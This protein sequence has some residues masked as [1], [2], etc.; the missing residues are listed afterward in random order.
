MTSTMTFISRR[1]LAIPLLAVTAWLGACASDQASPLAHDLPASLLPDARVQF[2]PV[3]LQASDASVSDAFGSAVALSRDGNTLAVGADLKD[4]GAGAVYVYARMPQGW[5]QQA[6]LTAV[7]PTA[8]SG[9][10]F[11]LSLSDDGRRLAVGAPFE[12]LTGAE[13]GAAYLFEQ[14]DNTFVVR[15][16]LSASNARESDWFGASVALSGRGDALAVGARHEDGPTARPV[17]DSGA[18][19]VFGQGAGGWSE[20][21]YLKAS[22]AHAGDRF[23]ASVALSFDGATL[24]VGAQPRKR[25]AVRV[26]KR[27]PAGWR[28]QA[29]LQSR[30]AVAQ[31]RFGAQLAL[32]ANGDTLAVGAT[33]APGAAGAAHVYTQRGVLWLQQARLQA[34]QAQAGDA[35]GERLALSAD[36]SVL[37]VS[38]VH[39]GHAIEAGV[40]HLFA[41]GAASWSQ[42][43]RLTSANA[44]SGDLFGSALGLSGDG[45]L[46]A[47]GARLEDGPS[48]W[49]LG[50]MQ[51]G[52]RA[53]NIGAVHLLPAL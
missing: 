21:A 20:Q 5:V 33:G 7:V 22:S 25:G 38:A 43:R 47:V 24:A 9:F 53:Q 30:G 16:H 31:D 49:R 32:S 2:A 46:L 12:S 48:P 29:L 13:Q 37:A 51:L 18:V 17:A 23:G 40:V 52:D 36:G 27:T 11:S 28:E 26:F 15:A 19:Y 14:Q 39:G 35:F 10:G 44:G 41:R 6:R 42:Q 3:R 8:G 50:G 34:P 1:C 4:S 45:R